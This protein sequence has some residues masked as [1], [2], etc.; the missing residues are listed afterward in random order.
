[1]TGDVGRN[2]GRKL[3][4]RKETLRRL[5]GDQLRGAVG[6]LVKRTGACGQSYN[7][8][9]SYTCQTTNTC[10][11][12]QMCESIGCETNGCMPTGGCGML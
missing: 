10:P 3:S 8:A 12:E 1:M 7:C 5:D 4:L 11:T 2:G 9:A 6:G